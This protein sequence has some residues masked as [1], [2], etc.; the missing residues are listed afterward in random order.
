MNAES[1]GLLVRNRQMTPFQGVAVGICIFINMLDGFDVLA[2]AFT[3]PAIAREWGLDPAALGALFSAGLAGMAIGSVVLSPLA[4]RY[5][6]RASVLFCLL[7]MT[8]GMLLSAFAQSTTHLFV[9]RLLTGLG[10]GG[11]L[12]SIN[13]IVAEYASIKRRDFCIGLMTMGYAVGATLGGLIAVVLLSNFGW[14][15]V[16]LLGG[17]L[18]AA[19]ALLV[20]T[21]MPESVDFLLARRPPKALERVNGVLTRLALPPLAELPPVT[22]GSRPRSE[23]KAIFAPNLRVTTVLVC[24]SFFL[25]MT[26]FYFL[27][28][29]TPKI[30][31]DLGLSVQGG[32]SGSVVM[33]LAGVVGGLLLGWN[34]N[35]FGLGRLTAIY[36]ALC[37]VSVVVFGYIPVSMAALLSVAVAIGFFMNGV[38]VGLYALVPTVYPPAVRAT[39]AGLAL[40]CGRLGATVGPFVAGILIAQGWSR[41]AY[42]IA[43][44]VPMLIAAGVVLRIS[45][46]RGSSQEATGVTPASGIEHRSAG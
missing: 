27:L 45:G 16:F 14:P 34:T 31:V 9:L 15:S 38:I 19:T 8:V 2:L 42:F 24:A 1:I 39:G 23:Y 30:L 28:N 46:A 32:I 43:M 22:A 4:D 13:T 41:A 18:S 44:A 33:N 20:V 3:A 40:G 12:P 37:F 17:A 7:L 29:W 21:V 25:A 36:M 11:V 35:R 5:G 26:T 10:I 6:R